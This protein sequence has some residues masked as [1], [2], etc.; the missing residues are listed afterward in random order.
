MKIIIFWDVTPY[1]LFTNISDE[2]ASYFFGVGE[3]I[4]TIVSKY[5]AAVIRVEEEIDA[6]VS[7]KPAASILRI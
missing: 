2:L 4:C 1:N 3:D 6:I 5:S 7:Q